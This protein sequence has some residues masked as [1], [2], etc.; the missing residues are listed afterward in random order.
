M[1]RR[2][3]EAGFGLSDIYCQRFFIVASQAKLKRRFQ[4]NVGTS[5]DAL[6]GTILSLANSGETAIGIV[7]AGFGAVDSTFQNMDDSFLIAPDLENV[8]SLVHASQDDYRQSTLEGENMP[9]SYPAARATIERYAGICSFT[10]MQRLVNVSVAEQTHQL[11]NQ[12]REDTP[13]EP[14]DTQ[15]EE[16]RAA[17]PAT[18][19]EG[20]P[21]AEGRP[22]AA[23]PAPPAP[24]PQS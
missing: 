1:I 14:T 19:T 3:L 8:R 22:R 9:T 16:P 23:T 10:S 24:T 15:G 5:V 6:V 17:Q 2:Y 11:Q 12:T 20:A 21:P 18:P 4:R 13:G 7:N